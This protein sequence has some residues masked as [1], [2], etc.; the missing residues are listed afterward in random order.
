MAKVYGEEVLARVRTRQCRAARRLRARQVATSMVANALDEL[1]SKGVPDH[2]DAEEEHAFVAALKGHKLRMIGHH[3]QPI[4][5]TTA[6]DPNPV[7]RS[8]GSYDLVQWDPRYSKEDFAELR[9]LG[10]AV[11]D[12]RL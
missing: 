12:W 9:R 5:A 7:S 1:I 11:A 2:F 3:S 4:R 6:G 8:S 10:Y